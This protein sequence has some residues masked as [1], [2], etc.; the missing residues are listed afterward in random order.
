VRIIPPDAEL[1]DDFRIEEE[2]EI[3][4]LV[5]ESGE[6]GV[7]ELLEGEPDEGAVEEAAEEF[8]EVATPAG[9]AAEE[10][11][12]DEEFV[13][14]AAPDD[15]A[16]DDD[17]GDD[18]PAADPDDLDEDT[19]AEAEALVEEMEAEDDEGGEE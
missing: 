10:P 11:D 4:N 3:E 9:G 16:A 2:A 1:P 6:G 13:E 12:L 5:V 7:E 15:D 19:E 18:E 17:A 14:E 8:D